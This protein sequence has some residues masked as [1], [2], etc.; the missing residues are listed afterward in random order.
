[1]RILALTS[2]LV[3]G[4]A[5]A[6]L[7]AP[8]PSP[9]G[10]APFDF[11]PPELVVVAPGEVSVGD[12]VQLIGKNFLDPS[13]GTMRA[14]FAGAF[15]LD[16]GE[17]AQ[18]E[19]DIPIQF[20]NRGLAQFEFGPNVIFAPQGDHIGSFSGTVTVTSQLG[21]TGGGGEEK[22]S[23]SIQ[24]QMKVL[25]SVILDAL[26]SVDAPCQ[27]VTR[28]TVPSTNLALSGRVIGMGEASASSPI[29]VRVHFVSPSLSAQFSRDMWYDHWPLMPSEYSHPPDGDAYFEFPI[30]SGNNI[31]LDPK[32][33]QPSVTV[34]P[35]VTIGQQQY[36]QVKLYEL[37][38]GSLDGPGP[39]P[40]TFLM[41]A[42]TSDGGRA[43]RT[44]VV[45]IYNP[46][47]IMTYD[48]N[49]HLVERYPADP[50]TG[51][52]P[53][54][55]IGRTLSYSDGTSVSRSRSLSFRWD[56]QTSASVGFSVSGGAPLGVFNVGANFSASWA[57]TFGVDSSETVTS[58]HSISQNLTVMVLPGYYGMVYTQ[59]ERL[60]KT[61]GMIYHNAC[62]ASAQVGQAI[63]TDW[64]FGFDIGTGTSCPPP[65]NLPPPQQFSDGG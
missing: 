11:Q 57:Q 54:G 48:G 7:Y 17:R 38:T 9:D 49:A 37:M 22:S 12:Q 2:A 26:H 62:G 24:V 52:V 43:Q 18:Y 20:V 23:P 59:P 27:G 5:G 31:N 6:T 65:T 15:L 21:G 53:G 1:M 4:C 30:T 45:Q 44:I 10:G 14:H 64:N 8:G 19:G 61:V 25:P 16:T 40:V 33:Q 35:P 41:E 50:V 56:T 55:D 39:A 58:E 13:H 28:S 3:A 42:T 34:N 36:A 47:E 32:N 60:Q 29:T 51:C 46:G 63:L